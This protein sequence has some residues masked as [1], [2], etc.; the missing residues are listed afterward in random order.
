MFGFEVAPVWN[1]VQFGWID[2]A[3]LKVAIVIG[4]HLATQTAV[5]WSPVITL[6]AF[7]DRLLNHDFHHDSCI[8]ACSAMNGQHFKTMRSDISTFAQYCLVHPPLCFSQCSHT[9]LL[10]RKL[11]NPSCTHE[12]VSI[13]I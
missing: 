5:Q 6:C 12:N 8:T 13:H 9:F 3:K 2:L 7:T 1:G 10:Q 11:V 4:Y